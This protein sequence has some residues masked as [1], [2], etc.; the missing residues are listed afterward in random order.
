MLE[1]LRSNFEQIYN[2]NNP[3]IQQREGLLADYFGAADKAR[4]EYLPQN[5]GGT[6]FSPTELQSLVSARQG[7]A[8]APLSSLNQLIMG[9]YG[10]L[11]NYL[12]TAGQTAQAYLNAG[13]RR[14]QQLMESAQMGYDERYRQAQLEIAENPATTLQ[15]VKSGKSLYTFNPLTGE[16][17]FGVQGTGEEDKDPL[18]LR[19]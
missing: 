14:Q 16:F 13:I 12:S 3:L 4:A 11:G 6:V 10:S 18:G 19:D 17:K 9:Q 8:L 2:K 1:Q 15:A 7:G 5:Y